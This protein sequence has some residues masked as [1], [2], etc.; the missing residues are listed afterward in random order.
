MSSRELGIEIRESGLARAIG[1]ERCASSPL[2]SWER[3]SISSVLL[4]SQIWCRCP[5]CVQSRPIPK[6]PSP[7]VGSGAERLSPAGG[8]RRSLEPERSEGGLGERGR[9]LAAS[10]VPLSPTPASMEER[11][12]ALCRLGQ[13]QRGPTSRHR[14]PPRDPRLR[15]LGHAALGP[16]YLAVVRSNSAASLAMRRLRSAGCASTRGA[17]ARPVVPRAGTRAGGIFDCVRAM[18]RGPAH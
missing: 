4:V 3:G 17:F 6:P 13:A 11:G 7:L 5:K 14:T 16:T 18:M 1:A 12:D 15:A 9:M 2:P 8:S 10:F